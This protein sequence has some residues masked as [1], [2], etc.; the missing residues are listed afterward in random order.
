MGIFEQEEIAGDAG[1]IIMHK[2]TPK[3]IRFLEKN[4][5]GRSYA[6]LTERF[7][8]RFGLSLTLSQMTYAVRKYTRGNGLDRRFSPGHTGWNKGISMRPSPKTEFKKGHKSYTEKPIGHEYKVNGFTRI[9]T[10][11]GKWEW[12]HKVIWE[13]ENGPLPEG[14]LIL[15][16]DRNR[17]NFDP[18]N[19]I[20]VSRSELIAMNRL[21]VFVADADLTRLGKL[22]ADIRLLAA[23]RKQEQ[24]TGKKTA[25]ILK[26]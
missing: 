11:P 22:I 5:T 14:Y 23:K 16:A 8:R 24:K 7:N 25:S 10:G 12:K 4:I 3:E 6:D 18:G 20:F 26:R 2:W 21:G 13:A 19:L 9:K 15:F 17:E 1:G